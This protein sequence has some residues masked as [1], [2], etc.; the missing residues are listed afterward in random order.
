MNAIDFIARLDA[1][2]CRPH[3]S[4]SGWLSRCPAHEDRGPS[5]SIG[6]GQGGRVLVRCFAGCPPEAVCAAVGV[7]MA[8]LFSDGG[9]SRRTQSTRFPVRASKS[10]CAIEPKPEP[11][12]GNLVDA[13]LGTPQE[14]NALAELRNV[15]PEA[16]EFAARR[17]L[18]GFRKHYGHR[19]WFVG[20]KTGLNSQ[21][22][23]MD[24]QKWIEIDAKAWTLPK[25]R[26]KWPV[27]IHEAQ[28]FPIIALVEGGPDL[29]AAFHFIIAEGRQSDSTSVAML[30]GAHTIPS[31][32]LPLFAGKRVRIFG[33]ADEAGRKAVV[34]W[35]NQLRTVGADVDAFRFD[36]LH[37]AD[38]SLIKDLND[39]TSIDV[40][41]FENNRE[42]WGMIP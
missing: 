21:A 13:S 25:S 32:A 30:G 26:A 38:G 34:R 4:A 20:D 12:P 35:A 15:C 40:D 39:C 36:G 10:R 6:E 23:R 17:G 37:K 42:L 18:I 5:L 19:A 41:D 14:W 2:G 16:V 7:H 24:G 31:E 29:L 28:P 9:K 8:D 33:H 3:K 27:G 22:R 11:A 1:R